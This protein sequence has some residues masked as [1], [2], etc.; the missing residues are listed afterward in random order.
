MWEIMIF[1]R[2]LTTNEQNTVNYY[3]NKRYQLWQ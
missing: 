3:L 1:N 2:T